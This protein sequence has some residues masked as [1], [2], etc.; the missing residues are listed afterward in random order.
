MFEEKATPYRVAQRYVPRSI[1][2]K[3]AMLSLILFATL[4]ARAANGTFVAHNTPSFVSTA[5]NLGAA[6]PAKTIEVSV[7]TNVHNRSEMDATA[8]NLYDRTSPNYRHW[9]TRSQI[10]ALSASQRHSG[11]CGEGVSRATQ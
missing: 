8:R 6:D 9:L 3:L 11:R 5:K 7:W 2:M 1:R 4:T 10:A